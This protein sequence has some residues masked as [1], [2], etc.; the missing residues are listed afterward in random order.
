MTGQMPL[1]GMKTTPVPEVIDQANK[2]GSTVFTMVEGRDAVECA[3]EIAAVEGVDV[4]LIGSQDLTIDLGVP[5]QVN[6]HEYRDA[7]TK[8][9]A[10]CRKHGKILGVAGVYDNPEVQSWLINEMG[11]RFIQVGL[12]ASLIYSGGVKAVAAIESLLQ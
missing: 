4:L 11:A 1:F 7:L 5:A 10:A 8:V 3:E 2:S 12:D 6:S 9:S